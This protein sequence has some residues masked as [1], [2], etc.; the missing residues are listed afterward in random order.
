MVERGDEALCARRGSKKVLWPVTGDGG[1]F[2][3]EKGAMPRPV[4][5]TGSQ[6]GG[7]VEVEEKGTKRREGKTVLRR[8]KR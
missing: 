3:K 5:S 7:R 4:R 8:G 1:S 2:N 6:S